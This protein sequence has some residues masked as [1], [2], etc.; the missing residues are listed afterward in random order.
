[1]AAPLTVQVVRDN[2]AAIMG[3]RATAKVRAA[4]DSRTLRDSLRLQKRGNKWWLGVPHYWAVYY[5]DGRSPAL[6]APQRWLVWYP[7]PK[8]DPRHR[9]N[10]PVRATQIR[11]LDIPWHQ[12]W[13][14][15]VAGR[16]VIAKASP[17]DRRFVKGKPFFEQGLKG[18][19]A[20]GAPQEA[21]HVTKLF[22]L[23]YQDLYRQRRAT[24]RLVMPV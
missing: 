1:M 24:L 18:F 21:R 19:F 17:R 16:A 2:I 5:H 9:G 15:V 8:D 22:R 14:D 6:A 10:Y 23:A 11:R 20:G 13:D 12:L 3:R 4:V 7:N